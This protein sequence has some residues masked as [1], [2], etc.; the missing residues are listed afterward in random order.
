MKL[1]MRNLKF[2][3]VIFIAISVALLV[4][5]SFQQYRSKNE[6]FVAAGE[7][8]DALEIE[9]QSQK[10]ALRQ[11]IIHDQDHAEIWGEK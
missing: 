7:N 4:G 1:L 11:A 3:L 8:K 10:F 9:C 6:L 2:V 5:L